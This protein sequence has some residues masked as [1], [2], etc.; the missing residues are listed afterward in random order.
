M[1]RPEPNAVDNSP[2]PWPWRI[3]Q[4]RRLLVILGTA[5]VFG[6]SSIP[7]RTASPLWRMDKW[8][9]ILEYLLVGLAYLNFIT[10]GFAQ[11]NRGK[12]MAFLFLLITLA[13]S[14]EWHQRFVP[15]RSSNVGDFLASTFG[16][17]LALAVAV[18]LNRKLRKIPE[19]HT[20][21]NLTSKN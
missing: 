17:I 19:I 21:D 9:H 10:Q 1:E 13:A 20:G 6:L 2:L 12:V 14:D 15:G 4:H 16:G 11:L 8:F 5:L 18:W 3:L 7:F